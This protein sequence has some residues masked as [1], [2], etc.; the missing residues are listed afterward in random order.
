MT[1]VFNAEKVIKET[2]DSLK[3]QTFK[4][5]ELLVIDGKSTDSTLYIV[6]SMQ[7]SF[8]SLHIVSEPDKG[9]YDAMNKGISLAEGEYIYFLNAG[10]VLYDSTVFQQAIR[11]FDGRSVVYG[12]AFTHSDSG[13]V[14]EY[15]CGVYSKYRLAITNICHQAIFYPSSLIKR[16]K[17]NLDYRLFADYE[18][19]M[20]LWK[21]T[22]FVYTSIPIITYEGGGVSDTET[23]KMFRTN[24]RRIVFENLGLDA[25]LYIVVRKICRLFK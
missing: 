12:D 11:F 1:V 25:W 16:I 14:I 6:E 15:R 9:I 17:Y 18:L 2:L 5:F 4:D 19:N 22:S 8:S 13:D 7:D 23:D 10:D 24:R 21:E 3:R 20:R